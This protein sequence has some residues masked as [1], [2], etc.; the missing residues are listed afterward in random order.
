MN[1][2][3]FFLLGTGVGLVGILLWKI[4]TKSS[5]AS[6]LDLHNLGYQDLSEAELGKAHLLDL[7][8]AETA[9]LAALRLGQESLDRLIE[10]RP[11]R[12]KLDLLSRMVVSQA[13]YSTIK[14]KIGIA[15]AA[16]P[17]KVG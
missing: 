10:N 6:R 7:N 11:Y 14:D 12:S 9:D 4:L 5:P 3:N 2:R 16:E 8:T 17:L 13:E 1:K 15:H